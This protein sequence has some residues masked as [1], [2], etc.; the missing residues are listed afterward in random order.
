[1]ERVG[2]LIEKLQEQYKQNADPKQLLM[3]IQM[4][5]KE[6]N[7]LPVNGLS[8]KI[9]VIFPNNNFFPP[10]A[11]DDKKEITPEILHE[12]IHDKIE[13]K[14]EIIVEPSKESSQSVP[15]GF[16]NKW[17]G[18]PVKDIPTL[19]H[20]SKDLSPTELNEAIA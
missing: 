9:S 20:Q 1:M 17:Y 5:I 15:S 19:A 8:Q 13:V 10:D 4:L 2:V 18:D 7:A 12:I 14:Q 3:T 16:L 11:V 6:L